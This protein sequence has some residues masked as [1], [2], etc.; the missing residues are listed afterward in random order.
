MR[1]TLVGP[2]MLVGDGGGGRRRRRLL[3]AVG[4]IGACSVI[5]L[6]VSLAP[7]WRRAARDVEVMRR[8]LQ[9]H[10]TAPARTR[11]TPGKTPIV[12]SSVVVARGI[13]PD[14]Q[15]QD[16]TDGLS[17]R[18]RAVYIFFQYSGARD[19]ASLTSDWFVNGRYQPIRALPVPLPAGDGHGHLE[20][21]LDRSHRLPA[22]AYRVDLVLGNTLVGSADFTVTP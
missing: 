16:P 19:G 4:V 17:A 22:G 10:S 21:H 9:R 13:T 12:I 14:G 8:G 7:R 20:L 6:M 11:P 5:A 2:G 18:D 15:P 3:A 1:P